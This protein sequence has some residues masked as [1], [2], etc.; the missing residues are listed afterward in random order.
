MDLQQFTEHRLFLRQDGESKKPR[1]LFRQG[2]QYG[3][4]GLSEH[5]PKLAYDGYEDARISTDLV[6]E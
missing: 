2:A 6:C 5:L 3:I 1:Y 4:C